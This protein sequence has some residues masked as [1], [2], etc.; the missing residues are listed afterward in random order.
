[1]HLISLKPQTIRL[2]GTRVR[3]DEGESI[4]TENSYKFSIEEFQQ[5]AARAGFQPANVWTDPENLFSLH[6]L[7]VAP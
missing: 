6:Y 2:N 1:M 5:L 4:H 7:T 3:F